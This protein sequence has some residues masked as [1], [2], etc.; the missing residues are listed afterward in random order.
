MVNWHR[1]QGREALTTANTR[2]LF[3]SF[4][5]EST[6]GSAGAGSAGIGSKTAYEGLVCPCCLCPRQLPWS[7]VCSVTGCLWGQGTQSRAQGRQC[8]QSLRAPRNQGCP[9]PPG[10]RE[11]FHFSGQLGLG[12][13]DKPAS[14]GCQRGDN[15]ELLRTHTELSA[16]ALTAITAHRAQGR[17]LPWH[18]GK[19][20]RHFP[21]KCFV[22]HLGEVPPAAITSTLGLP[23]PSPHP[24]PH[25]ATADPSMVF[26]LG[27][28]T[29]PQAGNGGKIIIIS[30]MKL[31]E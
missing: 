26:T 31:N 2:V 18:G 25:P 7:R 21:E 16:P 8:K 12:F 1:D 23:S 20:K 19:G 30:Q 13:G 27:S 29:L 15:V 22:W 4:C 3:F 17:E 24:H 5:P 9:H 28:L 14:M 11:Q 10:P 6:V